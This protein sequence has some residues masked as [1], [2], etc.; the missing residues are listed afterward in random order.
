M[1]DMSSHA[2]IQRPGPNILVITAFSSLNDSSMVT[3]ETNGLTNFLHR[4]SICPS[5]LVPF[6]AEK[7][8]V[9]VMSYTLG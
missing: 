3:M 9:K 5:S 1:T 2:K 7:K 4:P 6:T 8:A